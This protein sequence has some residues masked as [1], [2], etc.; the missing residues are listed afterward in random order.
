M[1]DL[2]KIVIEPE[3]IVN[4]LKSE[5]NFKEVYQNILFQ[6]VI[7]DA[8]QERGI[9]VT[10]AEIEAE[11]NRQRREKRLEKA[12]DTVAWLADQ[13]ISPFDWETGIRDRLLAQ[14]LT[15]EL[16]SQE[17]E[18]FFIQNRLEF[19][20]VSL[21]QMLVNSEKIAQELYYQIAEGEIT[22]YEAAHF[23]DVDIHR[24]KKC[25]YEGKIYRFAL[26]PDIAAILFSTPPQQLIGPVKSQ[27]GYHL[28][29][30]EEFHPAVLTPQR[31]QEIINNMFKHWLA[32]EL[33]F[34]L[35]SI[36]PSQG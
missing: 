7:R 24:Q 3:E 1:H 32:R 6:R 30:V 26:Q 12:A 5:I 11:A 4:F 31:Y 18:K 28:F 35:D 22:F 19:E 29:I 8:A 33:D 14:K 34:M 21:Y 36:L 2:T 10:T 15:D 17:V 27:Q 9:T 25:G 23:Y 16:F 20:Q 13:L